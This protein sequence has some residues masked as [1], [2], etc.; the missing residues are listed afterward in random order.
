MN[1]KASDSSTSAA[2]GA[3]EVANIRVVNAAPLSPRHGYIYIGRGTGFPG[4]ERAG[5]G[6][7]WGKDTGHARRAA[8]GAYEAHLQTQ[9]S[10]PGSHEYRTIKRLRERHAAGENLV[11]VCWCAPAPCHGDVIAQ[12]IRGVL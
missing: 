9:L 5:L 7:P 1:S 8:I 11:L 4:M 12:A 2:P 6:N 3:I 10:D